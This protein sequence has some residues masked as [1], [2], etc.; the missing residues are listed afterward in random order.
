MRKFLVTIEGIQYEVGVEEIG[1]SGEVAPVVTAAAPVA[2]PVAPAPKAAPKAAGPVNGTKLEA[3]MPGM[4]KGFKVQEG[5][6]VKKG[7]VVLILEAMKMDN[8]INAP[9]DGVVSFKT[10]V[11]ANVNTG[12]VMAVIG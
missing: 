7:D 9:C 11:G 1:A 10:Q 3:P 2:A 4:I 8:D 5:A 6:T 12:D